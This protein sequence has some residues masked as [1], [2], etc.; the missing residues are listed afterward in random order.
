M[1]EL[2]ISRNKTVLLDDEDFEIYSKYKWT[3]SNCPTNLN[4]YARRGGKCPFTGKQTTLSM[5]RL[6]MNCP[7]N[8]QVDHINGNTLDNRKVNLRIVEQLQ[9]SRNRTHQK[10]AAFPYKGISFYKFSKS[11]PYGARICVKGKSKFLGTF[12]TLEEAARAYNEAALKYF[13]KFARL[14]EVK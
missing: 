8:K 10:T 14:N 1:K 6:I 4:F 7:K 5:H 13:G 9:N 2:K 3:A 11:K 12:F